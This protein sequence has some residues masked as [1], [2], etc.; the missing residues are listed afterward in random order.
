M[1]HQRFTWLSAVL[2]VGLRIPAAAQQPAASPIPSQ[3]STA[4]P[5]AARPVSVD[6][7]FIHKQFG[8][9]F[10]LVPIST[11]YV[12]DVDGDGVDD[13]IVLAKSKKPML[14]AAEHNYKVTDPYYGFYG[15]GDPKLTAT[16]GSEDPMEKNLV[17]L[18]IHGAGADAWR[19]ETP[20]AKFVIINLPLKKIFVK[21]LQLRKKQ[22]N[23]IFAVEAD[24]SAG[25]SV[26]FWDGKQYKYQPIGTGGED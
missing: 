25:D 7:D 22:V 26:V 16:F 18:V 21:R 19:A 12:R 23:A 24:A 10:T 6:N 3:P 9:E 14:D 15:Y 13:F 2:V 20:K 17:V 8:E 5:A 11:P 1:S 4:Q